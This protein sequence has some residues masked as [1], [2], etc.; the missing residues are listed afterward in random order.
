MADAS[1]ETLRSNL[2]S[3]EASGG[4][5]HRSFDI[6]S[7]IGTKTEYT[8][9]E[10]DAFENLTSRYAR[11]VDFLISKVMRSID[12]VELLNPAPIAKKETG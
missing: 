6:C 2:K 4:W 9:E 8:P 12:A 1:M 7:K 5:L 11:T 10:Y 3:L